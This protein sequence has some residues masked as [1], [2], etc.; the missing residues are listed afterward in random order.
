MKL[1]AG[2]NPQIAKADGDAPVQ[3]YL[4]AIPGWK[5]DLGKRLDALITRHVPNV[6][7]AVKWSSPLCGYRGPGGS[8]TV[9][10]F[11]DQGAAFLEV[12]NAGK[13]VELAEAGRFAI[14]RTEDLQQCP[15][16][17]GARLRPQENCTPLLK[18]IRLG[19]TLRQLPID[20]GQGD[21][22]ERGI[23]LDLVGNLEAPG[24]G[25][26]GS[27]PGSVPA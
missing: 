16:P 17:H 2:G 13:H 7:K 11:S 26:S 15:Q 12:E 3:A 22:D 23:P 21:A 27:F 9:G 10:A 8:V 6:R 19:V 14:F 20:I 5:R 24:H 18:T 25:T 4:A 1:L